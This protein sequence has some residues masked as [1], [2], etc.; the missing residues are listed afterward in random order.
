MSLCTYPSPQQ[1]PTERPIRSKKT[2]PSVLDEFLKGVMMNSPG[3][4]KWTEAELQELIN[5]HLNARRFDGNGTIDFQEMRMKK[6]DEF[7]DEEIKRSI[8]SKK[9]RPS[10]VDTILKVVMTRLPGSNW[11]EAEL[12]YLI[13]EVD[14]DNDDNINFSEFNMVARRKQNKN[15]IEGKMN[16]TYSK[17][18]IREAFRFFDKDGNGFASAAELRH[19]MINLRE[20]RADEIIREIK[21]DKQVNYEQFVITRH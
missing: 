2:K 11:T 8:R 1:G 21:A 18:E 6:K 17:V 14:P 7:S 9:T 13:N 15:I 5:S 20:E 19:V 4:H 12:Q 16:D 3:G 10:V